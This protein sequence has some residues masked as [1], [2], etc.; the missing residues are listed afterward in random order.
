MTNSNQ[1]RNIDPASEISFSGEVLL[2]RR[3]AQISLGLLKKKFL[4]WASCCLKSSVS[5]RFK[6]S[7][8]IACVMGDLATLT[9]NG[10]DGHGPSA[11]VLK[12]RR[13]NLVFNVG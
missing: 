8:S 10:E 2:P 13:V 11:S 5:R 4:S 1:Q 9:R 3:A 12:L 6:R 7:L